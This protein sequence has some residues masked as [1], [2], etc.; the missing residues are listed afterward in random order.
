MPITRTIATIALAGL[1][2]ACSDDTERPDPD[3]SVGD[4]PTIT[5]GGPPP[6]KKLVFLTPN[7]IDRKKAG[8]YTAAAACGGKIGVAYYRNVGKVNV[9]CP[10]SGVQTKPTNK[11]RP[12]QDVYYVEF[13]GNS[14]STPVRVDQTIG[15]PFGLSIA[16]DKACK[17]V[18]IG[19]TGG[20]V[21]GQ[22]CSASNAM[23]ASSSDGKT[24]ATAAKA[25]AGDGDT[26]GHWTSV[27]V[28][29]SGAVHVAHRDVQYGYYTQDGNKK[30]D[31]VYDSTKVTTG[32]AENRG[33]GLYAR[34]IFD[35]KGDPMVL[36]YNG[37]EISSHGGL[38][39][40]TSTGGSLDAKGKQLVQGS[41]GELP[42]IATDGKGRFGVVYY[43]PK[44][45]ALQYME[46]SDLKTWSE[47]KV[48]LALTR[49]GEY[50]SLAFDGYGNPGIAYYR[51]SDYGK[52]SCQA[53]KDALMFAYR[54]KGV[55]KTYEVDTG[56]SQYCGTYAALAFTRDNE[57]VIAYKCVVFDNLKNDWVDTLKTVIGVYQ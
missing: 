46:S 26:V 37:T 54:N 32:D 3:G 29:S 39:L 36:H 10:P 57:P 49:N 20:E 50:S 44:E 23:V 16:F 1:L 8:V 6:D 34:L 52:S 30:A 19:Y 5:E 40:I 56:D 38:Q 47:S 28:D 9:L 11:M 4:G 2:V 43:S 14:W 45:Q 22:E 31:L 55:W 42:D 15:P 17:T 33:A 7:S 27:G 13:D 21:N 41:V 35:S 24:F 25:T 53:S 12:A 48:D 51:C 18:H